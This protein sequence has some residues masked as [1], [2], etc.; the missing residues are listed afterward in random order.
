MYH[1]H[2]NSN[3]WPPSAVSKSVDW[4]CTGS[5][6]IFHQIWGL[7]EKSDFFFEKNTWGSLNPP[8]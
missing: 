8:K 6:Q 3:A 2:T 7:A 4:G 5:K 1:H